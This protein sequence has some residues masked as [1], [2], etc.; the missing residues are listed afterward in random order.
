MNTEI[1]QELKRLLT[2]QYDLIMKD[3]EHLAKSGGIDLSAQKPNANSA[4]F[5]NRSNTAQRATCNA[6]ND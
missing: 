3:C 5:N 1:K 2:A 4:L 6:S